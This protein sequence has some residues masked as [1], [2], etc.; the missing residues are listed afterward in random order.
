M[1][2]PAFLGVVMLIVQFGLW[3]DARQIALAAAQVGARVAREE[4]FDEHNA[5]SGDATS[6]ATSYY[7]GLNTHLLGTLTATPVMGLQNGTPDVGVTV[8]GPLGFSVFS[9]FGTTWTITE[10]VTGPAECFHPAALDGACSPG[11]G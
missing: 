2:A 1:L 10:T 6:A 9:W 7:N 8:S 11:A 5:W 3:F 4:Y